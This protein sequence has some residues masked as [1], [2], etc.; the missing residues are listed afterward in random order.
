MDCKWERGEQGL[1]VKGRDGSED[2][3]QR[4]RER[5]ARID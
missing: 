5:G 2:R 3:F 4:A 1:I